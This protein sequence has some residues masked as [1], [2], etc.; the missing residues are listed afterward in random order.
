MSSNLQLVTTSSP[1]L[2]QMPIDPTF[3]DQR[4]LTATEWRALE[5]DFQISV[6]TA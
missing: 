2:W 1:A 6:K 5:F 3:Y 4:P